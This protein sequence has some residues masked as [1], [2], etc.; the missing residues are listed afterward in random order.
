[1]LPTYNSQIPGPVENN[2]SEIVSRQDSTGTH[3]LNISGM[4]QNRDIV[5]LLLQCGTRIEQDSHQEHPIEYAVQH[6]DE[7]I[8]KAF[9][10]H[11]AIYLTDE[12]I[13]TYG[14]AESE[15]KITLDKTKIWQSK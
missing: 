10:Q 7:P 12:D 8:M 11:G 9:I 2:L 1:M 3:A 15:E 14:R 6:Q 13:S 5:I 4:N